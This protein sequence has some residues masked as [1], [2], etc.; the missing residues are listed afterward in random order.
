MQTGSGKCGDVDILLANLLRSRGEEG[1]NISGRK[2]GG[3]GREGG[4]RRR[5]RGASLRRE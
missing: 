3:K 1:E 4:R 5:R 2:V